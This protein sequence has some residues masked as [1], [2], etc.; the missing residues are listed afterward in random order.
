[1]LPP[2]SVEVRRKISDKSGKT[3]EKNDL[4]KEKISK[5]KSTPPTYGG[6][7]I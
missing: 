2:V 4:R 6:M 7:R 3:N 1:M 5:E